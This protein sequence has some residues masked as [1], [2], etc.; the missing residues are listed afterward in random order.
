[1]QETVNEQE[2]AAER[3]QTGEL[4]SWYAENRRIL[5]WREDPTPYHVW[6]SEIMLQQ[7]RV[8]A[9]KA[10]YLRF[11]ENLPDIASLA[12]APEEVY[13]KLWEGLGYYSRVRNL[14]KAAVMIMEEYG[15]KMPD[16]P[17]ELEKLPGIGPYSAAAIAS[18][19]FQKPVVSVDGN[20]L[21][22]F[23]RMT[24]YGE[25]IK[26]PAARK[27]ALDYYGAAIS[28]AERPGDFNQA[29]MDLGA[30][31]CL[32]NGEPLCLLC[33]W[34]EH[35][36]AH[37]NGRETAFPVVPP[38]KERKKEKLTV[39]LIR[40]GEL[41]AVRR[42]GEDGLLAGLWEFPNV[43]GQRNEQEAKRALAGMGL[44]KECSEDPGEQEESCLRPE[45]PEKAES[46]RKLPPAK[47]I[48][49]HIEW[50]MTGY[51]AVIPPLSEEKREKLRRDGIFFV[52]RKELAETYSIPSAFEKYKKIAAAES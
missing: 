33:P 27:A 5:P 14:H 44:W 51:E 36:L 26:A 8:E 29:L 43:P 28:R 25:D 30:G 19:A 37:R 9:G 13:L 47:H 6:L 38:K 23:A 18:I 32:P 21:R 48:F 42:R 15:G 12:A 10:Y 2:A 3:T 46:L 22:V 41:L 49:S 50:Y 20:L 16:S 31:I 40:A 7:T 17:K 35:C 1:M 11:L 4:L 34:K 52:T 24:E 45:S 39:F